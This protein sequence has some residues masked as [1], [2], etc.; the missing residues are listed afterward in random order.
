MIVIGWL[1]YILYLLSSPTQH[2]PN[3]NNN[4][5]LKKTQSSLTFNDNSYKNSISLCFSILY[6]LIS[7]YLYHKVYMYVYA[8]SNAFI[9]SI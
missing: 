7:T 6:N 8:D 3:N 4:N 2:I 9:L 5:K 1:K